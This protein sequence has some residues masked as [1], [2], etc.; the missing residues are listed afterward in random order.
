MDQK[1]VIGAIKQLTGRDI[2]V[3]NTMYEKI[4]SWRDWL[5]GDV[6][7]FYEY[8]MS[9]DL[10]TNKQAKITRHRTDM[11]K[12]ACEDWASL[13]LNE[14]TRFELDNKAT[15][16]WLQG[17]DGN[18]GIL[19]DNDFRRNANE[20]IMV[21][22]WAG[23]AAFEAYV[24]DGTVVADSGQLLSGKDIG[25]NFLSGDQIIPISH[26]NGIIKEVAFVSEKIIDETKKH[27][28]VSM[29]VLEG[30]LYTIWYFTIDEN[31]KVIG[32]PVVVRTGSSIPWFS[33]IRKAGYN[34][35]DPAG[36]FGVGILD[37]NE[38]VLKGLD[39]AFDNFITDFVLGRKMVFMNSTLFAQDDQGRFIAPQMMGTQLFINVGDRL[40]S[41][42]SMLEEYN[43]QLRVEENANGV[44]RMLDIFSFKIGLGKGFYKLD[45]DGMV[46]TATEYTGSKQ[47][48]IRNISRE[49]IGI[50]AAL[51]QLIEAVLWIGENVLHAPGA[52]FE[53][54]VRVVADDSYITD[55]Y[56]ERKVWQEEVAQRLRSKIEYRKRFMG[57]SDEEA[58]V[59]I[60][61]IRDESPAMSDLLS[62]EVV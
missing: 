4:N 24:E 12:R 34:R 16:L 5:N 59:A 32:E 20:L 23:T 7:G 31:G 14:L 51:K 43:P 26:R 55:E 50:Q 40:K 41:D 46:K 2:V 13:L 19:G 56:T 48:L 22:R 6:D 1:K 61:A 15:E 36:P 52:K 47:G 53:D 54:D 42:K 57:E 39:T 33:V 60:Q 37:G 38:D 11:F 45:E 27:H 21:S 29:H 44:Q 25:I 62:E 35:Y 18:G 28:A 10:V 3:A 30:G 8:T 9:V 49:M 17:D 58:K